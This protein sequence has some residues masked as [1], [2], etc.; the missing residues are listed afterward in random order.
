MSYFVSLKLRE[1]LHEL[2]AKR[3]YLA[4]RK[5]DVLR[6]LR[7]CH[8]V[9]LL[10]YSQRQRGLIVFKYEVKLDFSLLHLR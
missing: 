1:H 9:T 4:V 3:N 5:I 7:K 2:L 8:L 6:A 10:L